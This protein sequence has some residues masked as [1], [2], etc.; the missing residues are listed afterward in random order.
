MA[1]SIEVKLNAFYILL[2]NDINIL[3]LFEKNTFFVREP[4]RA[5]VAFIYMDVVIIFFFLF[6]C[7]NWIVFPF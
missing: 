5:V 7:G 3:G 2:L 1:M 6:C 4:S